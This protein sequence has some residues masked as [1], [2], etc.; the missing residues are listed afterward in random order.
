MM[1]IFG[2][3]IFSIPT[4]TY[5]QLQRKTSWRYG[6]NNR[7][8]DMPAYQFLGRGEDTITL[9]CSI[10]PEFGSQ[11][12]LTALRTMGD[13]GKSFPLIGGTGKVYGL[14]KLDDLNET[15]TYFFKDGKP[16]KVDFTLTL[17]QTMRPG[18]L[19]GNAVGSLIGL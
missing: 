2:V 15:Q 13:F 4:A 10:V 11:M 5:Q 1:M 6:S 7:V 3:F 19:I 14:Y 16:R 9:Q 12:S 8:G 18:T 17:T